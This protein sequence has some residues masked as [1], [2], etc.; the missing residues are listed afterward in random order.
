VIS[1]IREVEFEKIKKTIHD[2]YDSIFQ[3][4][5]LIEKLF[6]ICFEVIPA[7]KVLFVLIYLFIFF[8]HNLFFQK[9]KIK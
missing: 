1:E 5:K 7:Y 8:L 6:L 9:K 2:D 4:T 3:K